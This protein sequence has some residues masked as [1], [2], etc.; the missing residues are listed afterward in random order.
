MTSSPKTPRGNGKRARTDTPGP[1]GPGNPPLHT[2]FVLGVSG[3]PKGRPR[4]ERSLIKLIEAELDAEIQITENGTAQRLS[5]REALA[6]RLVN[7][8]LKGDAKDVT[9]LIRLIGSGSESQASGMDTVDP[10]TVLAYL[11]RA[12]AQGG[13]Q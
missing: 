6:K 1:V 12:T 9:A 10:A 7:N 5:K 11:Q 8:A 2:R 3:N 4:K 13:G